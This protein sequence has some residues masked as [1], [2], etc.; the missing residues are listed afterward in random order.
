MHVP[1]AITQTCPLGHVP[2]RPAHVKLGTVS[3]TMASQPPV[4]ITIA[5]AITLTASHAMGEGALRI[6]DSPSEEDHTTHLE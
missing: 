1:V 6:L 4:A 3:G 2:V 5:N